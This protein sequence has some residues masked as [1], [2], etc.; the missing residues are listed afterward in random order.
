[1]KRSFGFLAVLVGMALFSASAEASECERQTFET[2]PMVVCT[3]N[4]P[5]NL[6]LFL[7]APDGLPFRSFSRVKQAVETEGQSLVFAFNAGMYHRDLSPVG[8]YVENGVEHQPISTN[9]GPGNFHLLPNG[10]F[11]IEKGVAGVEETK[12]YLKANR[13]PDFASQSGPMLVIEGKLH[14]RFLPDSDSLKYR[15]GVG[16]RADG[17]V[18]FAISEAKINFHGFGRFFRDVLKTPN[19]LYFD[20]T[21]SSVYAPS[22]GRE[23]FLFPMGPIVGFLAAKN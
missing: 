4:T 9:K 3:T 7:T 13:Q 2:V 16:V 17:T 18:V 5:Q 12:A 14:P 11:W 6:R 23:D 21:V 15:N 22:V 10:V 8:L 19:A 1:M 20:G